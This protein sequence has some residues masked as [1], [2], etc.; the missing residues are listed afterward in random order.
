MTSCLN[1]KCQTENWSPWASKSHVHVSVL[2]W[3]VYSWEYRPYLLMENPIYIIQYTKATPIH[4]GFI[5]QKKSPNTAT[6][7]TQQNEG[8]GGRRRRRKEATRGRKNGRK[9]KHERRRTREKALCWLC[10]HQ[11]K[12]FQ[13]LSQS[14]EI[15]SLMV[16]SGF[17]DVFQT[18]FTALV[19]VCW[20]LQFLP[21]YASPYLQNKMTIFRLL[22][23]FLSVSLWQVT[24]IAVLC[25]SV[26]QV[27]ES[28]G[29]SH[30]LST[31]DTFSKPGTLMGLWY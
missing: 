26:G 19:F 20:L 27:T 31:R 6:R 29:I 7:A 18:I 21:F 17:G 11:K 13:N 30:L 8:K 22:H 28:R 12:I 15:L 10:Q 2:G 3:L 23:F 9:A 1:I 25:F 16:K 4:F 14:K 24:T 5:L